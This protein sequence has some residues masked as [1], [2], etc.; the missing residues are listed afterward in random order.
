[1]TFDDFHPFVLPYVGNCPVQSVNF[2]VLQAAT[3]FC[4][5]APVWL[6]HLDTVL[7]DAYRTEYPL[8]LD[9]QVQL[10]KLLAVKVNGQPIDVLTGG[11]DGVE[12]RRPNYITRQTAYLANPKTLVVLPAP[13]AVDSAIDCYAWLKPSLTAFELPDLLAQHAEAVSRGA[14]ARLYAMPKQAWTDLGLAGLQATQFR[15][16]TDVAARVA[17]LANTRRTPRQPESRFR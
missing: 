17:E 5:R 14:L 13:A 15:H 16:D 9:D 8:A 11:P 7:S 1:M 12:R 10:V 3:E 2:H 6:E 4:A